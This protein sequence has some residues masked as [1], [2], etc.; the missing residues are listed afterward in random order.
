MKGSLQSRVDW[1]K[2]QSGI[3]RGEHSSANSSLHAPS[4]ISIV[5]ITAN[6]LI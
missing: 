3:V 2:E 6:F 4:V 5:D 1:R